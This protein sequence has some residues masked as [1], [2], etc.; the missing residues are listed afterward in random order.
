MGSMASGSSPAGPAAAAA[1][2]HAQFLDLTNGE[3]GALLAGP[4]DLV[5]DDA[6]AAANSYMEE[7]GEETEGEGNDEADDEEEEEEEEEDGD[8]GDDGGGHHRSGSSLL[9]DH[10]EGL[11]FGT[12][13]PASTFA[14]G[15]A[16][17]SS[18]RMGGVDPSTPGKVVETGREQTG[19]WTK[20]E[21]EAFLSALKMYGKEWKK[22]AAK[23]KTRTV[24]QTR[25]HA[26]KYFQKLQKSSNYSGGGGGDDANSVDMG[27]L[28][29]SSRKKNRRSSSAT[30]SAAQVI[31]GLS[32]ARSNNSMLPP[33]SSSTHADP[34]A[35]VVVRHSTSISFV[36]AGSSH[37]GAGQPLGPPPPPLQPAARH[38]FS[39]GSFMKITAPDPT[40][41][42]KTVGFP[43][44]S[45]AATGKR[46]LAEIAAA[47]MLAGVGHSQQH[48][49]SHHASASGGSRLSG[50]GGLSNDDIGDDDCPP[51][52]PPSSASSSGALA[53]GVLLSLRQVPPPPLALDGGRNSG[54]VNPR[55]GLSLQIVNPDSLGVSYGA[56]SRTGNS[57]VTPW[58]GQL[59]ALVSSQTSD[60]GER[61]AVHS[62][63]GNV[64]SSTAASVTASAPTTTHVA[65]HAAAGPADGFGRSPLHGAV[66]KN[67]T[68][69]VRQILD[70]QRASLSQDDFATYLGK[71]DELGYAPMHTACALRLATEPTNSEQQP[72]DE[73]PTALE[74]VSLLLQAGADIAQRDRRDNT[75]LHWAARAG[76]R[77]V[78]EKLLLRADLDARNRDGETP[79]HWAL[80]AGRRARAVTAALLESG[81]RPNLLS[82]AFKRPID[83]AVEG[84]LDEPNSYACVKAALESAKA[85]K[86]LK[87]DLSRV[88]KETKLNRR[89]TRANLL[90]RSPHSRTLVLHHPECL[91]HHPKSMTD[92]ETPD[93]VVS[94]M[95]RVLPHSDSTGMTETSGVFPHEVTVSQDFERAKLDLLRR[96]H[97]TE[98]LSFVNQ[99]SKDLERQ[100][101]ENGSSVDDDESFASPPP[102]VPFTPLVQRTMIKIDDA[103]VKCGLTSDTSFSAGSL[104]AARRAAG[105]VQ[106]AID[107]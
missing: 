36:T 94:I 34:A 35:A 15:N 37:L 105:S 27:S 17:S 67:S 57:P 30:I 5:D 39:S 40:L 78:A 6:A 29:G 58:D 14:S 46:K 3:G 18:S 38:G 85:G 99:L 21:H 47:R 9:G 24:V 95:R 88:Q 41:M 4:N 13:A 22:V 97:S 32:S 45:P 74:V 72:D 75:P 25:T 102:V 70:E 28:V 20:E 12:S 26:Q 96:V 92:W 55:Q 76:D 66:C 103:S 91:E 8:D 82:K 50:V 62:P 80:R 42:L 53:G 56:R 19:R 52:P 68:E 106:H 54:S 104:R 60:G 73:T 83:V 98:Y 64:E 101:K 93:R 77:A 59:E 10:S 43:E 63:S 90:I 1:T 31:S 79:L 107:W 49:D 16:A 69:E 81:A 71:T 33:S 86:S 100:V 65:L 84:F 51:T 2:S 87:K 11:G 61:P 23:V 44:P 48:Q 7:E 89:E